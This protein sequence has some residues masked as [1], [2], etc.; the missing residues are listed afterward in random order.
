MSQ[1]LGF[2]TILGCLQAGEEVAGLR[3][4]DWVRG[5]KASS[6][7][8]RFLREENIPWRQ[9]LKYFDE[10]SLRSYATLAILDLKK[11]MQEWKMHLDDLPD[12]GL[13]AIYMISQLRENLKWLKMGT[14]ADPRMEWPEF[15]L[16][17][18]VIFSRF[19]EHTLNPVIGIEM[20]N[21]DRV[22]MIRQFDPVASIDLRFTIEMIEKRMEPYYG[23][24]YAGV[25]IPCVSTD[26][27][28]DLSW[29]VGIKNKEYFVSYAQQKIL[30]GMN[31][32]GFAVR[33]ETAMTMRKTCIVLNEPY[34]LSPNGEGFLFWRRR[35][36]VSYPISMFW[37]SKED[38]KDPGDLT[39]I[40]E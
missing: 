1:G 13:G 35:P 36:G 9:S 16:K 30:F 31:Q 17:D 5:D 20:E 40:V 37:L 2:T 19:R 23:Y 8:V 6:E 34:I 22:Y 28:A 27:E 3:P 15:I 12:G 26:M 7:M 21:G 32:T 18:H 4:E 14:I 25:Q 24:D 10:D 11:K 29:L 33:E 39:K 38:F